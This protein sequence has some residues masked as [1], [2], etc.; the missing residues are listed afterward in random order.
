MKKKPQKANQ[1]TPQ[2]TT[3]NKTPQK[4]KPQKTKIVK[5]SSWNME[6]I[7]ILGAFLTLTGNHT[8]SLLEEVLICYITPSISVQN[9]LLLV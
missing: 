4:K 8:H 5:I 9:L 7:Q 1:K 2:K 3:T 6:G